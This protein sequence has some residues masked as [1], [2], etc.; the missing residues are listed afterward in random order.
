MG[1]RATRPSGAGAA[2]VV[3]QFHDV[4]ETISDATDAQPAAS[5]Q[6]AKAQFELNVSEQVMTRGRRWKVAWPRK[7]L[8]F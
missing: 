7:G 6:T 1:T 2:N 4:A 8:R 3:G 5:N